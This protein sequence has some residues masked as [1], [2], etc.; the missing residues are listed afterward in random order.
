ME[1]MTRLMALGPDTA[2]HKGKLSEYEVTI[3]GQGVISAEDQVQNCD[4][5]VHKY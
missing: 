1:R 5:Q 3:D 2:I 4:R